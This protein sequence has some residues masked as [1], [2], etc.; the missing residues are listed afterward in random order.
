MTVN[1]KVALE[2]FLAVPT[3]LFVLGFWIRRR[4]TAPRKWP[5]VQGT[6]VRCDE[7]RRPMAKGGELVTPV[8]EYDFGYDGRSYKSS[9]WRLINYSIGNSESTRAVTSR[10]PLGSQVAV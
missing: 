9:H 3:A 10:Y 6:I 2:C 1:D 5:Q 4:E 8:I 7:E